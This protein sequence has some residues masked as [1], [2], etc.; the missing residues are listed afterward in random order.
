MC[1]FS[2]ASAQVCRTNEGPHGAEAHCTIVAGIALSTV[3]GYG[4]RAAQSTPTVRD[5]VARIDEHT[6]NYRLAIRVRSPAWQ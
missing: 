4:F 1:L 2:I 5:D 6:V 3:G